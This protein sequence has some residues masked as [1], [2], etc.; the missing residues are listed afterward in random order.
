MESDAFVGVVE[1][2][3]AGDGISDWLERKRRRI[4]VKQAAAAGDERNDNSHA[5]RALAAL[6]DST[7]QCW[8]RVAFGAGGL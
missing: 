2:E 5:S 1:S 3:A 7:V 6:P 8:Y 4:V